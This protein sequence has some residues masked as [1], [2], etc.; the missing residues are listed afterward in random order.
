MGS[1]L[2]VDGSPVLY[3]SASPVPGLAVSFQ[4]NQ[5]APGETA[6]YRVLVLARQDVTANSDGDTILKYDQASGRFFQSTDPRLEELVW[7]SP[8]W[9]TRAA[10]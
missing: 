3:G 6:H 1:E 9:V 7:T 2:T 5:L 10:V 8:V 4:D